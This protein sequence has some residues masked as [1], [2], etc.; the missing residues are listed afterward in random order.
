MSRETKETAMRSNLTDLSAYITTL[1]T[2]PD[3]ELKTKDVFIT[4]CERAEAKD[5]E[6][7]ADYQL[8]MIIQCKSDMIEQLVNELY[9]MN[10]LGFTKIAF[11]AILHGSIKAAED[12][13][14][15]RSMIEDLLSVLVDPAGNKTLN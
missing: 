10:P 7:K 15:E 1:L 12:E 5:E 13:A 4:S 14:K 6:K 9:R 2:L 8:I 11:E 3:E